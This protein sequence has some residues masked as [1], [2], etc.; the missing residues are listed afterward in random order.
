[1]FKVHEMAR[2]PR[3]EFAG[4]IYHVMNRGNHLEKIF[5]DDVD[6]TIFLKMLEETCKASGWWVHSFVLM[7]NHYHLLIETSR[8]TLV[9]GMQ[10]LNSTYTRRYNARHKTFGHLFQGRYKALLVDG[11]AKGYFLTVSDYIHMNPV[12]IK[13]VKPL[14]FKEFLKDPWNS[15]GW[16]VG[17]MKSERPNWLRWE[18]LYGELGIKVWSRKSR[19]E[20]LE[21]LER[22]FVEVSRESPEW[23]KIRRG[24]RFGSEAFV[25]Q[26]KDLLEKV[27][28]RPRQADSWAGEAVEEMEEERALR[29][30]EK[31]AKDLGYPNSHQV[32]GADRYL[33]AK[34]VRYGTRV[35]VPWLAEKLGLETRGGMS[36][37]ISKITKEIKQNRKLYEQW[38]RL[39]QNVA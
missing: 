32:K 8:P 25:D 20:Y 18:R 4:A 39:T 7:N 3:I 12:R 15:A 31:G 14:E 28:Q 19:Y 35:R 1:M 5:S 38:N 36:H 34:F 29:L 27:A 9:K 22:R 6:R 17:K 33:L 2:S 21:Y 23:D 30:L 11:E 16:L 13:R 24:W 26:M 37:G 10:Y